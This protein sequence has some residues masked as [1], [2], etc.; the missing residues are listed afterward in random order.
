MSEK[1]V[2]ADTTPARSRR[3]TRVV[4][5]AAGPWQPDRAELEEVVRY[6]EVIYKPSASPGE[7]VAPDW[8]AARLRVSGC[9]V[10]VEEE[11]AHGGYWWSVGLMSSA[12]AP[13]GLLAL[14][15]KRLIG[16]VVGTLAA[17]G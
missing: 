9:T 7:R 11:K 10:L 13:A 5:Q 14:R 16:A 8:I 4:A 15:G 17:A 12:G 1:T 3:T 2:P 6:L